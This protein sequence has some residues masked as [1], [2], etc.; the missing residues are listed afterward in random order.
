MTHATW[1]WKFV[2]K[3]PHETWYTDKKIQY[4]ELCD[5]RKEANVELKYIPTGVKIFPKDVHTFSVDDYKKLGIDIDQIIKLKNVDENR[6]KK[7]QK[8][9]RQEHAHKDMKKYHPE[10]FKQKNHKSKKGGPLDPM[11]PKYQ[12]LAYGANAKQEIFNN[13][14]GR[15]FGPRQGGNNFRGFR[16]QKKN[17]SRAKSQRQWKRQPQYIYFYG[18]FV[19]S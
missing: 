3:Y 16:G 13:D 10:E 2:W 15:N 9:S 19:C 17:K 4:Y 12:N 18:F 1:R 11:S 6:I 5:R 7:L 14:G 8:E